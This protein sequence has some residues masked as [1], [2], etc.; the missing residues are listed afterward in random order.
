LLWE[1]P[2][3][4]VCRDVLFL[5]F[6]TAVTPQTNAGTFVRR[7]AYMVSIHPDLPP[8][9]K[10]RAVQDIETW[11]LIFPERQEEKTIE[12]ERLDDLSHTEEKS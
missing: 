2:V 3:D 10:V 12:E 9:I 6:L 11:S 5:S 8:D 4:D 7:L 1:R